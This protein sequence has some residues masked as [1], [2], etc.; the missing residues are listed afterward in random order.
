MIEFFIKNIRKIKKFKN[1]LERALNAKIIISADKAIIESKSDD[2]MSEYLGQ[3]VVEAFDLGFD[4]NSAI[5]LKSED[6]MIE[7]INL[8]G[9]ARHSRLRM[10]KSRVIGHGGGALKTI[11]HLSD[12]KM[13]LSDSELS[14]IGRIEDVDVCILALHK[15]IGGAPHSKVYAFL[16]RSRTIRQEKLDRDEDIISRIK[17]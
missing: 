7:K 12:C 1:K 16:E 11:S 10:I 5:Q 14:V 9:H 6:F 17:K 13:Q 3:K 2:A 4:F 8:K 15:L